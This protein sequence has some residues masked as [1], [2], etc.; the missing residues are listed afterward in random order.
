MR[1]QVTRQGL[2]VGLGFGVVTAALTL[3]LQGGTA[4]LLLL[5]GLTVAAGVLAAHLA[6]GVLAA[7]LAAGV[8]ATAPAGAVAGSGG[9]P[10]PGGGS[11][12]S[13]AV[14]AGV[15]IGLLNALALSEIAV[16]VL[17]SAGTRSQVQDLMKQ[18]GV[19]TATSVDGLITL[20][21]GCAGCVFLL[22]MPTA[23]AALA[24]VGAGIYG[25]VRPAAK[26]P[27]SAAPP[28]PPL[29]GGY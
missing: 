1:G 27:P 23:L 15:V 28:L 9:A 13:A 26:A 7:H 14:A 4:M 24:A 10:A 25:V 11:R 3:W 6:A 21:S 8:P 17:N 18:Q 19:G 5:A 16:A 22:L 12:M 20:V 29:P 2:G